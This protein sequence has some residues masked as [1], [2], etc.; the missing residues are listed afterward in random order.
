[1][2]AEAVRALRHYARATGQDERKVRRLYDR[3]PKNHRE[4]MLVDMRASMFSEELF[5]WRGELTQKEAA[6][7]LD[8]PLQ[9]YRNWE[10]GENTPNRHAV[11]LLR[12]IMQQNPQKR[13]KDPN[14]PA[15]N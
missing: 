9:T 15:I 8:T 2:N 3:T 10:Q 1:M 7:I 5:H 4:A 12:Q 6:D 14:A 13:R 11:K